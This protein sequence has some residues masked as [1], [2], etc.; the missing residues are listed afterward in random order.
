MPCEPIR[1]VAAKSDRLKQHK[2]SYAQTASCLEGSSIFCDMFRIA[3]FQ[4]NMSVVWHSRQL[5]PGQSFCPRQRVGAHARRPSGPTGRS[6][7]VLKQIE[8]MCNAFGKGEGQGVYIY[9]YIQQCSPNSNTMPG[10][11]NWLR[12]GK[13]YS[14]LS[15]VLLEKG[16]CAGVVPRLSSVFL[17]VSSSHSLSC[18]D[19]QYLPCTTSADD[20]VSGRV[21][22]GLSSSIFRV[23]VTSITSSTP[24]PWG[25]RVLRSFR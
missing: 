22:A 25:E 20:P 24:T 21:C 1:P 5:P 4:V 19:L 7:V 13:R 8:T 6:L 15:G 3:P 17:L 12:E 11:C 10:Q 18:Y 2:T 14:L 23:G 9:I 16:S